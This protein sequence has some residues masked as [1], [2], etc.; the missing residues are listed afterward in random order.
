[1]ANRAYDIQLGCEVN[2]EDSVHKENGYLCYNEECRKQNVRVYYREI[3]GNGQFSSVRKSDHVLGCDFISSFQVAYVKATVKDFDPEIM[4]ENLAQ[5]NKNE[6]NPQQNEKQDNSEKTAFLAP[7]V[8][9]NTVYQLLQFC[10]SNSLNHEINEHFKVGDICIDER[11]AGEWELK[12]K[13]IMGNAE[14]EM[15]ILVIGAISYIN[16][17]EN[18][19]RIVIGNNTRFDIEFINSKDFQITRDKLNKLKKKKQKSDEGVG[20]RLAVFAR[21][22]PK[23]KSFVNK[24]K[25]EVSYGVLAGKVCNKQ[26]RILG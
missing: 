13:D 8:N 15:V 21:F 5:I 25:K 20:V 12:I 24:S 10:R 6:E 4:L 1:M 19:I 2:A 3:N 11:N 18:Y 16:W 23:I 9:L 26:V 14:N 17:N 7:S 22:S